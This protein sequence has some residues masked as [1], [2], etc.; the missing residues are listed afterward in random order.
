MLGRIISVFDQKN[1]QKTKETMVPVFRID[2][3]GFQ[4]EIQRDDP[5]N[6]LECLVTGSSAG[7][8]A[9]GIY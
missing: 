6:V 5:R 4:A 7:G 1:H 2:K 8:D 3:T 9:A